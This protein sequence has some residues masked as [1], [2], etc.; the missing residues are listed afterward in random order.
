MVGTSLPAQYC[1]M[2]THSINNNIR[3]VVV[4]I[5]CAASLLSF[6]LAT[7]SVSHATDGTSTSSYYCSSLT[8]WLLYSRIAGYKCFQYSNGTGLSSPAYHR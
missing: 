6:G 1:L 3:R 5:L 2:F 7:P 4:I 8:P